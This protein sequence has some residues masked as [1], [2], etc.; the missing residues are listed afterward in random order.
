MSQLLRASAAHRWMTCP[1]S[2]KMEQVAVE[3][4]PN[5]N[6]AG[7]AALEGT[8]I[9][10]LAEHCIYEG[11]LPSE[12]E[13]VGTVGPNGETIYCIP[14]EAMVEC[15]ARYLD[16]ID[17]AVQEAEQGARLGVE[18]HQ[19]MS[20]ITGTLLDTCIPDFYWMDDTTLSVHDL[21]CGYWE[22]SPVL[23]E[24]LMIY[25][26]CIAR[27]HK[28]K[29]KRIL[30]NIHQVRLGPVKTFETDTT[31]LELFVQKAQKASALANT[32]DVGSE[33]YPSEQGCKFCKAAGSCPALRAEIDDLL[34]GIDAPKSEQATDYGKIA[35]IRIW[36]DRVE[37]LAL[38]Q[39]H[40]GKPPKG[41][42][43]VYA[44]SPPPAWQEGIEATF[45]KLKVANKVAY[46]KVPRTPTQLKKELKD[47]P[48]WKKLEKYVQRRE[49]KLTLVS[50][51]DERRAVNPADEVASLLMEKT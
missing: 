34:C 36:C 16:E 23:N 17:I 44:K 48:V 37:Q 31:A 18:E 51:A 10:E 14:T 3:V 6:V 41:F 4:N 40:Q 20:H 33:L 47:T 25:A 46:K 8:F 24:Q 28:F 9:H 11:Q 15:A 50:E 39:A 43:L 29:G 13:I 26:S 7:G 35:L 32:C 21:K 45:K 5:P 30:L 22:V 2:A 1:G 49:P 38:D 19:D 12:V 42:K 27:E